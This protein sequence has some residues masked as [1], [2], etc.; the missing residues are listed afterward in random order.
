MLVVAVIGLIGGHFS[1]QQSTSLNQPLPLNNQ[2]SALAEQQ[3]ATPTH[4]SSSSEQQ[5]APINDLQLG[6][7]AFDSGDYTTALRALK[8]LADEGNPYAQVTLGLMYYESKG[9]M[10]DYHEALNWFLRAANQGEQM[11]QLSLGFMYGAGQGVEQDF[12]Q[13]YMRFSLCLNDPDVGANCTKNRELTAG[14]MTTA[15]IAEGQRL[16]AGWA[17]KKEAGN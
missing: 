16:A 13:S 5:S 15:Q 6:I 8:P 2:A 14:Q 1:K 4:L 9:V 10:Q 3:S 12:V 11:A 17:P 7:H